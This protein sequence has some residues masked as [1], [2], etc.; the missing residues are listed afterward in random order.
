M[1]RIESFL[2]WA[3]TEWPTWK[4]AAVTAV[5]ALVYVADLIW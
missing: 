3:V 4:I 2:H 5:L 1:D